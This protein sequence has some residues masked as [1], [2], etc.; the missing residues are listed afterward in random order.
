[1][2]RLVRVYEAQIDTSRVKVT[3]LRFSLKTENVFFCVYDLP[4]NVSVRDDFLHH[5]G[6]FYNVPN[7]EKNPSKT[8]RRF[9]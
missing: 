5:K 1:M 3:H 6:R 9:D 7:Y 2:F 8:L 4:E